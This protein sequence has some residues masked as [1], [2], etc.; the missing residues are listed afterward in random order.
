MASAIKKYLIGAA[1]M[2]RACKDGFELT[3][4]EALVSAGRDRKAEIFFG[5]I[6]GVLE[7]CP[8]GRFAFDVDAEE[9]TVFTVRVMAS[10]D[11]QLIRNGEAVDRDDVM[12]D[13]SVSAREKLAEFKASSWRAED[14]SVYRDILLYGHYGR[15]LWI[16]LS[17]QGGKATFSHFR[18]YAPGDNFLGTFPEV[19]R[20]EGSFFHRYLSIFSSLY[21]DLQEKIDSVDALLDPDTA[22]AP[23]LPVYASWFGISLDGDLVDEARLRALLKKVPSLIRKKGTRESIEE[24]V[25]VFVDAPFYIVERQTALKHANAENR[26]ILERLYGDDPFSF[27]LLIDQLPDEKLQLRLT[28]LIE[29]FKP[30]RM[31]MRILFMR[32]SSTLDG[33]A[34]LDLNAVL[35]DPSEGMLDNGAALNGTEYLT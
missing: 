8:W 26:R 12:L 32:D 3:R 4:D 30:I 20:E 6:D 17:A 28:R 23:L 14:A 21:N 13:P 10:D 31:N 35:A 18:A 7:G 11:P 2:E 22:P 1:R 33:G 5:K 16:Y 9:D 34:N 29:Q 19:Y 25:G 15:Y 24:L 27:T